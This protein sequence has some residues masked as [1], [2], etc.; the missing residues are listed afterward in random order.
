MTAPVVG[1]GTNYFWVEYTSTCLL[2]AIRDERLPA[3]TPE[4]YTITGTV[5]GAGSTDSE[6]PNP[7]PVDPIAS[8]MTH[9]LVSMPIYGYDETQYTTY[10]VQVQ[11]APLSD[12][13][14]SGNNVQS[15]SSGP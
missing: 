15:W 5:S 11:V 6:N 1:D 13:T 2:G 3:S 10:N 14:F 4:P 8:L 7:P 12:P 9:T